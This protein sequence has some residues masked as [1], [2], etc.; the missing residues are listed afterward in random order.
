MSLG[1]FYYANATPEQLAE[2]ALFG[3]VYDAGLTK[4][5]YLH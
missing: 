4:V 1:R 3:N 5:Y 2:I